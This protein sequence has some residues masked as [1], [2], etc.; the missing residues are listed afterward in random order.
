MKSR[1]FTLIEVLTVTAIVA[2]LA[3]ILFPVLT[4]AKANARKT[5]TLNNLHQ[6]G[7]ALSLYEQDYGDYPDSTAV[8]NVL[9][10]SI[11]CDPMDYWR[12]SCSEPVGAPMVGSY[13]YVRFLLMAADVGKWNEYKSNPQA[14]V[15]ACIFHSSH[16]IIRFEGDMP[17]S[18]SCMVTDARCAFPDVVVRLA[19]DTS[20]R[21]SRYRVALVKD[22]NGYS[23]PLMTWS[24]V[25]YRDYQNDN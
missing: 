2:V 24:S 23:G 4:R 1:A 8:R 21:T 3:A 12:S 16:K 11:T 13:A 22:G 19:Y 17:A 14:T 7:L 6:C 9:N 18:A 5:T 20:A 25:F 15:M 10:S